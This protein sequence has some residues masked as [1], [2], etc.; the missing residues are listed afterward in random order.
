MFNKLINTATLMLVFFI[1]GAATAIAVVRQFSVNRKGP[2]WIHIYFPTLVCKG[3]TTNNVV[4]IVF[5]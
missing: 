1:F 2:A 5:R 4:D 3:K